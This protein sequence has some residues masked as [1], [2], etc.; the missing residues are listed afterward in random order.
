MN[1][2]IFKVTPSKDV[3]SVEFLNYLL[4]YYL[5]RIEDSA[6]GFK[7]SFLHV[8]RQGLT[9]VIVYLA[10][11]EEQKLL[12]LRLQSL[13]LLIANATMDVNK[14]KTI[15]KGLLQGLLSGGQ[16]V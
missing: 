3:S 6:H 10:N 8:T 13:D 4:R 9:S 11:K 14:Y 2:H 16:N 1:Q 15:K 7:E 5:E 12:S